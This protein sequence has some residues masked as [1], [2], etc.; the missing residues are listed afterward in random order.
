MGN[1]NPIVDILNEGKLIGPNYMS[2]KRKVHLVLTAEE[3]DWVI[4]TPIPFMH[5][6]YTS[7]QNEYNK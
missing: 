2:W 4:D 7:E 6:D 1:F 5:R 3:V